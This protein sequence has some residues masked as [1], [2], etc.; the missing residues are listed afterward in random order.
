MIFMAKTKELF[1]VRG[2]ELTAH[3]RDVYN[4]VVELGK[5]VTYNDLVEVCGGGDS[6]RKSAIATLARLEKTHGLLKKNEPVKVCT[7]EVSTDVNED[8]E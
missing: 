7:Y 4:K 8:V 5:K 1:N 3:E 6:G 2:R